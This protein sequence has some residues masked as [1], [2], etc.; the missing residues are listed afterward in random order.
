MPFAPAASLA[1]VN[2]PDRPKTIVLPRYT[3]P[4]H[5]QDLSEL[6]S[7]RPGSAAVGGQDIAQSS[8]PKPGKP[9]QIAEA[10]VPHEPGSVFAPP[11]PEVVPA[12]RTGTA[13][14]LAAAAVIDHKLQPTANTANPAIDQVPVVP[15]Q[16]ASAQA[17]AS[18][19]TVSATSAATDPAAPGS[20]TQVSVPPDAVRQALHLHAAPMTSEEQVKVL[21]LVTQMA[22]I[23]RDL[24]TQNATLRA[25]FAKISADDQARLSDLARRITMAEATN[26]VSAAKGV[27]DAP[28]A[29]TLPAEN[30]FAVRQ[31]MAISP[32]AITRADVALP[33]S[34]PEAAKRFR[35]QA[36]SPGLAL[37][38]EIARGG[39][40]GAQIQV[41]V[42]EVIPGWGKVQSVAQRGTSWV[43]RTEH[44]VIE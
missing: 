40:D 15:H 31:A 24:R 37:L 6:L 10:F 42:G 43:V 29:P 3:P 27:A 28:G 16:D 25:D 38:T 2:L 30:T 1:S 5:G 8:S 14:V 4:A 18:G 7:I 22:T 9:A 11:P 35:V 26:A 33:L 44:G 13:A 41:T 19:Q 12:S 32:V 17:P 36:A 20:S 21:D 23:V 39:G 34:A